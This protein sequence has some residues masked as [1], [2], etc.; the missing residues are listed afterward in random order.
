ML[1]VC[2][3]IPNRKFNQNSRINCDEKNWPRQACI[4]PQTDGSRSKCAMTNFWETHRWHLKATAQFV[5]TSDQH[6]HAMRADH[7]WKWN[8]IQ[9]VFIWRTFD[10]NLPIIMVPKSPT[11]KPAFLK[12]SG[13]A[14]MPVPIL[15][16]NRWI[17]VSKFDVG[18]SNV[19]CCD[20]SYSPISSFESNSPD[21]SFIWNANSCWSIANCEGAWI[22]Y[23]HHRFS[24]QPMRFRGIRGYL[25]VVWHFSPAPLH[26]SAAAA[27]PYSFCLSICLC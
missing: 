27:V 16:F 2:L 11:Y 7:T 22:T 26:P 5:W 25:V 6:M 15:P 13:I 21:D 14:R 19:R 17:I 20:G 23:R 12:A 24:R 4:S 3:R 1:I 9:F 18:C 8:S 10:R